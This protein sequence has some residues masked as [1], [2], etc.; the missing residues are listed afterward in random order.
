MAF[1]FSPINSIDNIKEEY[2][3]KTQLH[4]LNID[5]KKATQCVALF[6]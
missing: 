5:Q 1:L 2:L 6:F 3:G 4:F